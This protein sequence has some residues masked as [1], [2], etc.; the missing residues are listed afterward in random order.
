MAGQ[1]EGK[2]ALV[3]GGSAGIG[4]AT[5]IAFAREGAK[6]VIGDINVEGGEET[7]DVVKGLLRFR[8]A[9]FEDVPDVQHVMPGLQ[10]CFGACRR[11][12]VHIATRI[13]QQHFGFAG[14]HQCRRQ[15]G[16]ITVNG[17]Q[18]RITGAATVLQ[19]LSR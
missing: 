7:V 17:R 15:T 4:R 14:M 9:G 13:V 18:H 2:V 3:T 10:G 11:R 12:F 19:G 16:E 6:L 8:Q 5:A 1:L